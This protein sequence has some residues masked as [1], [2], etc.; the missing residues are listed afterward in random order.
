MVVNAS[1]EAEGVEVAAIVAEVKVVVEVEERSGRVGMVE[2]P[3]VVV[4]VVKLERVAVAGVVVT[5]GS[6]EVL[7]V[8]I[9]I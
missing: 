5:V 9:S 2:V 6:L 7:G 3:A 8:G 1:A 4:A